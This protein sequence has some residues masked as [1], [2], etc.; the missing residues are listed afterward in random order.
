ME[1]HGVF[2][3]GNRLPYRHPRAADARPYTSHTKFTQFYLKTKMEKFR[4][5]SDLAVI[6]KKT[7][8]VLFILALIT[9]LVFIG[10]LVFRRTLSFEVMSGIIVLSGILSMITILTF[11]KSTTLTWAIN[12][13]MFP[14]YPLLLLYISMMMSFLGKTIYKKVRFFTSAQE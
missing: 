6:Y 3:G 10:N 8:P 1:Q 9:H 7:V 4:I 13:P 2:R 5:L 11:A 14:V 12:R